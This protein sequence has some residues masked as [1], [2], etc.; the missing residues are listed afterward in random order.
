MKTIQQLREARGESQ[1][2]LADALGA[3]LAD[4][5]DLERGVAG[6]SVTR[7]RRLTEYFGVREED[8]ELEPNRP[9]SLG[10]QLRDALTE[11]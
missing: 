4:I 8:I 5:N 6:P 3:P 2:H 1:Q 9:P 11:E 7:L 10:E